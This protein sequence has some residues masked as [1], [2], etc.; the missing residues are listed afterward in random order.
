MNL[1]LVLLK[2]YYTNVAV[3]GSKHYLYVLLGGADCGCRYGYED[4]ADLREHHNIPCTVP[5]IIPDTLTQRANEVIQRNNI[6]VTM[7]NAMDAYKLL[8]REL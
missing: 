6:T 5:D 4:I 3:L 8:I 1:T 7:E 2:M